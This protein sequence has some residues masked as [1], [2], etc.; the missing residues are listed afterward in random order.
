MADTA[1]EIKAILT[2]LA[3]KLLD[4]ETE[5]DVMGDALDLIKQEVGY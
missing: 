5:I 2:D 4:G 1:T 3:Y